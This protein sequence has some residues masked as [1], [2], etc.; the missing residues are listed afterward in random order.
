MELDDNDEMDDVLE[1]LSED[2]ELVEEAE[3]PEML[4]ED[5]LSSSALSGILNTDGA[6]LS[7]LP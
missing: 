2:S 1:L 6:G 4:L 5:E 3:T 7:S